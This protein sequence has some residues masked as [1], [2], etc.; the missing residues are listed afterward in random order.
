MTEPFRFAALLARTCVQ[1]RQHEQ[2]EDT[3][4]DS[5]PYIFKSRQNSV[6]VNAAI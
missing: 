4:L 3:I 1:L 2:N 6:L 5:G